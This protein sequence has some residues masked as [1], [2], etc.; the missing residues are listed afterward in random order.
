MYPVIENN[1]FGHE[2]EDDC[3]VETIVIRWLTNPDR[4]LCQQG[5]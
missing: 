5:T 3:E 1:L 2:Y 4:G